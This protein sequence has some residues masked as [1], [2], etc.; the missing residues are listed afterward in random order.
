MSLE[1][2]T[3]SVSPSDEKE[4]DKDAQIGFVSRIREVHQ[5]NQL[6]NVRGGQTWYYNYL[7]KTSSSPSLSA[8][9][10][11]LH[12]IDQAR[13]ATVSYLVADVRDDIL[14]A[15]A[16]RNLRKAAGHGPRAANS[17]LASR[18]ALINKSLEGPCLSEVKGLALLAAQRNENYGHWHMDVIPS[19]HLA[20]ELGL[21]QDLRVIAPELHPYR[22]QSLHLMGVRDEQ[23]IEVKSASLY[24]AHVNVET[25]LFPSFLSVHYGQVSP[26]Q[27]NAYRRL[28]LQA[29]R[30]GFAKVGQGKIPRVYI[31]RTGASKR[32]CSNESELIEGLKSNGFVAVKPENMSYAEQIEVFSSADVICGMMGAALVNLVFAKPHCRVIE[33]RPPGF[34]YNSLWHAYARILGIPFTAITGRDDETGDIPNAEQIARLAK[35]NTQWKLSNIEETVAK[36]AAATKADKE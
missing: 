35:A 1:K 2:N 5:A 12:A 22:R 30:S 26:W 33:I 23:I 32:R 15:S 19:L 28:L 6:S 21:L 29:S 34:S 10:V 4:A 27:A 14:F 31:D 7:P 9:A 25:L 24:A 16:P 17:A 13:I 20:Q 3:T 8:P 36:V 18:E 11:G